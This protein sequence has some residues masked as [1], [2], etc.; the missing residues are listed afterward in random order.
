MYQADG[1]SLREGGLA[2]VESAKSDRGD[3]FSGAP[4]LAIE[5]LAFQRAR[6]TCARQFGV[7]HIG[8][9]LEEQ[10]Q[11]REHWAL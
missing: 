10:K 11:S 8:R 6:R 9:L 4:E 1:L 3:L 2:Q 5:H 7:F